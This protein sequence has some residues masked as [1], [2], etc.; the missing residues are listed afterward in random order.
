MGVSVSPPF[1]QSA[2]QVEVAIR[3]LAELPYLGQLGT[4]GIGVGTDFLGVDRTFPKLG[5]APEVVAWF[6]RVF[7]KA[8]ANALV[9]D[10]A[11]KLLARVAGAAKLA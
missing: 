8:D 2:D 3:T 5:D 10:N 1:F 9:H 11:R 7:G 4:V 6:F